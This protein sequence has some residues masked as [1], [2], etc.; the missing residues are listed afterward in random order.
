MRLSAV[1]NQHEKDNAQVTVSA[2]CKR[3]LWFWLILL[4]ACP[5]WL[6]IPRQLAP[7][8]WA[9]EAFTDAAGGSL[10]RL[11]AGCGGVLHRDWFYYPWPRRVNA[12]GWRIE[13]KKVGRKLS[14]LELIG[15]L[16]HVA[17]LLPCL[18]NKQLIIWVDNAGA[19]A[20]WDKGYSTRC[21]LAS[22]IVT[23]ISD[24]AAAVGCSVF[25]KKITRCSSTGAVL[26]DHLSKAN[27]AEFRAC[28]AQQQWPLNTEPLKLLVALLRWAD[29]PTPSDDLAQVVLTELSSSHPIFNYSL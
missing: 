21:P 25:L 1:A 12:G 29:R 2:D 11:G 15:P 9:L 20:I 5:G 27:F 13:G 26:A 7:M 24:I 3:Q 19:V 10:D 18:R 4:S 14:A 8:P 17:S 23:A 28:A 6:S 22:M 16:F